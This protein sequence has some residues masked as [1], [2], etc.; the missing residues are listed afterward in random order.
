MQRQVAGLFLN[1]ELNNM[2]KK[3]FSIKIYIYISGFPSATTSSPSFLN[4][5]NV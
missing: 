2:L 3:D 5:T 1:D 4:L